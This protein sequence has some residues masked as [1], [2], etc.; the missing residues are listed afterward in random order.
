M[1]NPKALELQDL[2]TSANHQI[3]A[4]A[5]MTEHSKALLLEDDEFDAAVTQ[6]L[7]E[8]CCK[9]SFTVTRASSLQQAVAELSRTDFEVALVD[10]NV[11]DS[12]GLDTVR[13][14][15]QANPDVPIIVLTGHDDTATATAALRI[16]AQDYLPKSELDNRTL[17]RIIQYAIERKEKET[18][19]TIKAYYDGLTGLANRALL[20]ERW[21][22]SL[23]RAKRTGR[24]MGVLIAD[25]NRFKLV[26]D[27]Y[28]HHAGDALLKEFASKLLGSVR[29]S[30]IVARLGGDEFVLV[31]ESIRSKEEVNSVRDTLMLSLSDQFRY[32]GKVL[33]FSASIGGAVSDPTEEEDLMAV[34]KR[35]DAEMYEFKAIAHARL[36]QGSSTMVQ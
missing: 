14:A 30:D 2:D 26:N 9:K 16:G 22:R 18:H 31:L 11:A 17:Q 23:A 24:R 10:M 8:K 32:E 27:L 12:A 29:E 1:F 35:A 28:G 19:L 7:L 3:K 5:H 4:K 15:I 33:K 20:Y 36:D 25:I 6:E 21:R 13:G 34:I